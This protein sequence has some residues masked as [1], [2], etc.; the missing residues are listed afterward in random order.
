MYPLIPWELA[1]DRLGS[2]EHTLRTTGLRYSGCRQKRYWNTVKLQLSG[3]IE[4]AKH[5]DMQKIQ[6]IEFFF[7]NRLHWQSISTCQIKQ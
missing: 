6:V 5:Q 4:K 1:P 3:L 2:T 7:K